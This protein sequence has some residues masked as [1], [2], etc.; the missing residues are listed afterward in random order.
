MFGI[1]TPDQSEA[2]LDE[3]VSIQC[4]LFSELDLG[5]RLLEMPSE[6]LGAPAYSKYDIE[7]WLKGTRHWAEV[8]LLLY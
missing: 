3:I 7:T 1:C 4:E 2:L 6:E 5:Y 8:R